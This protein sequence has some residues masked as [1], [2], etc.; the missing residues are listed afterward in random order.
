MRYSDIYC[1]GGEIETPNLASNEKEKV[2]K[3]SGEWE[4]RS[5]S[6]EVAD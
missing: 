1:F 4:K 2:L 3:Y 6:L 5:Y